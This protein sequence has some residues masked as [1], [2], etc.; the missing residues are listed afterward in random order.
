MNIDS[1]CLVRLIFE[2]FPKSNTAYIFRSRTKNLSVNSLILCIVKQI[3]NCSSSRVVSVA[4]SNHLPN[5]N[6]LETTHVACT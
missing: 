5:T 1:V 3:S 4:G 2:P 6:K